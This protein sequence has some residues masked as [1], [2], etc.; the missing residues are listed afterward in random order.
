MYDD[1]SRYHVKKWDF[2]EWTSKAKINIFR[3]KNFFALQA[4]L[5]AAQFD[6]FFLEK[7]ID[8]VFEEKN[9]VASQNCNFFSDFSPLL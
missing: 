5:G 6:F 7:P 1:S 4:N 2:L 3:K 8:L 9:I